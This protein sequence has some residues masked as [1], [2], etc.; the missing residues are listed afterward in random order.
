MEALA[1][2]RASCAAFLPISHMLLPLLALASLGCACQS[3]S[4]TP[5]KQSET[6]PKEPK[7]LGRVAWGR[8]LEPALEASRKDSETGVVALP[9]SSRLK[10]VCGLR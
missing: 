5:A 3:V 10:H 1:W 8:R 7:E 6:A 2:R 4:S 9:G